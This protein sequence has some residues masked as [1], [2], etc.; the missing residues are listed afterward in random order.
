MGKTLDR[1]ARMTIDQLSARFWMRLIPAVFLETHGDD[2]SIAPLH[3]NT[4][5]AELE[6]Q[7]C[8]CTTENLYI[9]NGD[10][11]FILVASPP[12]TAE[13]RGEFPK[14]D[15][16]SPSKPSPQNHILPTRNP[17]GTSRPRTIPQFETR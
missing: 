8:L 11:L 7:G 17:A 10:R 14:S 6:A 5:K 1:T 13:L 4:R 15:R 12:H 16:P 9:V 3:C 2:A